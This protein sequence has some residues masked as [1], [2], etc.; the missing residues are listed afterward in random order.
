MYA[1]LLYPAATVVHE[2]PTNVTLISLC[3]IRRGLEQSVHL[4]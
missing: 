3:D 2:L 1:F 4:K